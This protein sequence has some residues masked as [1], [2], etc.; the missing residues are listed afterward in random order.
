MMRL[1]EVTKFLAFWTLILKHAEL[2]ANL[3]NIKDV[4]LIMWA[5]K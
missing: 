3:F 5:R 4:L 2:K 1:D